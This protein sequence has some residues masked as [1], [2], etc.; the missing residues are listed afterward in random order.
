MSYIY[1]KNLVN[2]INE[3]VFKYYIFSGD[4]TYQ[5]ICKNAYLNML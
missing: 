2:I 3:I 1:L 5:L 4:K